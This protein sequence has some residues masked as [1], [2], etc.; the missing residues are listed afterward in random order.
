MSAPRDQGS[1]LEGALSGGAGLAFPV[2]N[3]RV[4]VWRLNGR[5]ERREDR[6]A[7]TTVRSTPPHLREG[8]HET[9]SW[10]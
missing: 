9:D 2:S 7:P 4:T 3:F 10:L 1:K 6:L 5:S 8:A